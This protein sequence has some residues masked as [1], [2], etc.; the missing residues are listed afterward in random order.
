MF[1]G[2]TS[3]V[4]CLA[5]VKPEWI[6]IKGDD[7]IVRREKW[8]QRSLI[9]TGSRDHSLRVWLLPKPGEREYRYCGNDDDVAD[10]EGNDVDKNLY[11]KLHL[12]G[13]D[14][15]VRAL[16]AQGRTIVSGSYDCTVRV[17]DI[18][19]GSCKWV[20]V[21]HTQKVYNVVLDLTRN[22]TCSG[23]MDGTVRVWNLQTGQCQYNL[24]GHTSLV[25]AL[26]LSPSYLVSGAADSTLKTWN[27][28][29]GE[30]RHTLTGHNGAITCFHHDDFKILSGSDGR[31]IMWDIKNGTIVRDL[32]TGIVGVVWRVVFEGRWCVAAS[33][34]QSGIFLD[35]WDFSAKESDA[36]DDKKESEITNDEPSTGLDDEC[37]DCEEDEDGFMVL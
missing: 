24:T 1:G 32:L 20:L 34:R 5:I 35:V 8:P 2:H 14:D 22:I 26:G 28:E 33:S 15:S 12:E 30:I 7:G 31:L 23:S 4:R 18:V 36:V 6:D 17:W 9:V 27:L 25:G 19:T 37:S 3:T 21:G 11:H 10:L 13:H 29:T 16:A